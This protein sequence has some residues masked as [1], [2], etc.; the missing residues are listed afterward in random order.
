MSR[1]PETD[2]LARGNHVVPTQVARDLE[3]ERDQWKQMY[4][5]ADWRTVEAEAFKRDRD[6]ARKWAEAAWAK[7][8]RA[9]KMLRIAAAK[10]DEWR[11][12]ADKLAVALKGLQFFCEDD[13]AFASKPYA[14]TYRRA[15]VVLAEFERLKGGK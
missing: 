12:C 10:A 14:A 7:S 5:E 13:Q 11:D 1:T 6:E 2:N 8:D 15:G 3:R 9:E 4:E